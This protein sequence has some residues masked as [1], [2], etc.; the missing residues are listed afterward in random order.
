MRQAECS[1]KHITVHYIFPQGVSHI[2]IVKLNSFY[3]SYSDI[4][5]NFSSNCEVKVGKGKITHGQRFFVFIV[6]INSYLICS[7]LAQLEQYKI[8]NHINQNKP[9]HLL[10]R[11]IS[12][13]V[14][15][16]QQLKNIE[17]IFIIAEI[18]E[19]LQHFSDAVVFYKKWSYELL[20]HY[21]D[22]RIFIIMI[23]YCGY[24]VFKRAEHIF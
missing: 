23:V 10:Y 1:Q 2:V 3:K 21:C 15:I 18:Q 13:I 20:I 7:Q 11:C 19:T 16:S 12:F 4:F 17:Y 14:Q 6:D 8:C 9:L 5:Y 24:I 22:Y